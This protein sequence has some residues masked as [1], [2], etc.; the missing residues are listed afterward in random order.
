MASACAGRNSLQERRRHNNPSPACSTQ[1]TGLGKGSS[2]NR[3]ERRRT[4]EETA[5]T[6]VQWGY[7]SGNT[8]QN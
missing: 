6:M 7:Q 5:D 2:R 4:E 1:H 3:R 8:R